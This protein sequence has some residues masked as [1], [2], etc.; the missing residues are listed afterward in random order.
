MKN[1]IYVILIFFGLIVFLTSQS[2]YGQEKP[3]YINLS[4]IVDKL[5]S[6]SR[7]KQKSAK[8]NESLIK[9]IQ[10]R[11]VNFILTKENE[12]FLGKKG[13]NDSLI[14]TIQENVSEG[15]LESKKYHEEMDALFQKFL[16][17]RKGPTLEKYKIAIAAAREYIEQ[18]KLNDCGDVIKYLKFQIPKIEEK[19][20]SLQNQ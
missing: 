1:Q 4:Y 3:N 15:V 7:N 13:G 18:V 2:V 20:K 11:K 12:D 9:E 19:I 6:T 14:K 5:D 17:N 10:E 16:N 8:T